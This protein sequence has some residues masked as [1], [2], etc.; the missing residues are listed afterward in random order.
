[1]SLARSA[2]QN[3]PFP[4][5]HGTRLMERRLII[6]LSLSLSLSLSTVY[7]SH[8]PP[9]LPRYLRHWR[10]NP[11]ERHGTHACCRQTFEKCRRCRSAARSCFRCTA[12][13]TPAKV[14]TVKATC[15]LCDREKRERGRGRSKWGGYEKDRQTHRHAHTQTHRQ[16]QTEA[17]R[18]RPASW[19]H[20]L[21]PREP[22]TPKQAR[23]TPTSAPC[24]APPSCD[25]QPPLPFGR[26]C[27]GPATYTF[28]FGKPCSGTVQDHDMC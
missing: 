16:R 5:V 18:K 11:V 6:S 25:L 7:F 22:K 4:L 3:P 12:R 26:P 20:S 24:A 2:F 23:H 1:M 8:P 13:C 15:V 27:C 10:T 17:E 21:Q 9:Y 14:A 19:R 28:P